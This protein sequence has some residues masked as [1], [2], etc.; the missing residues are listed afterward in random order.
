MPRKHRRSV[1][2][3]AARL[4]G[5]A[6]KVFALAGEGLSG[7][8]GLAPFIDDAKLWH[9]NKPSWLARR[10]TFERHPELAWDWYRSRR[11]EVRRHEPNAAHR[12]LADWQAVERNMILMTYCTAGY[13]E[14]AGQ[15]RLYEYRGTVWGNRCLE[16]GQA[17]RDTAQFQ[18]ALPVCPSCQAV[19]RP[20][21]SWL[22]DTRRVWREYAED[23][24]YM[25]FHALSEYDVLLVV[26]RGIVE[27]KP[28]FIRWLRAVEISDAGQKLERSLFLPGPAKGVLPDLLKAA[29]THRRE[30]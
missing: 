5:K 15:E 10:D 19:E 18:V 30:R 2:D 9:G 29:A 7:E 25:I 17:R 27:E 4:I 21:V 28:D 1:F 16:C 11:R 13:H 23:T 6:S 14:Q 20:D 12:A 8:S 26:G 22:D 24:P 3:Q